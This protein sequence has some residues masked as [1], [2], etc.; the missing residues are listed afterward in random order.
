MERRGRSSRRL[1]GDRV[2]DD[3]PSKMAKNEA[4][5]SERV[6]ELLNDA[7]MSLSDSDKIGKLRQVQELILNKEPALLDNFTDE[8]LAFQTDRSPEVR[9]VV[10]EFM[11]NACKK[12]NELLTKVVATLNLLLCD[13]NVN[14]IKKTIQSM[15]NLYRIVLHWLSGH[16]TVNDNQKACWKLV[17]GI[18]DHFSG[19][20]D[21]ENDGVRTQTVKFMEKI[22]ITL[23]A[24]QRGS[25]IPKKQ[26]PFSS[27]DQIPTNHSL[28][29]TA[30]LKDDGEAA[31]QRLLG[32]L[33]SPSISSVNL[34]AT[35]GT[36][37]TIA[38]Q[39]P[40]FMRKVVQAFE[41]LHANL[42]PTLAKTQVSSVR[43]HLKMQMMNMLR[44]Q[45]SYEFHPQ[46]TNLLYDLGTS[47]SEIAKNMPKLSPPSRKRSPEEEED[48]EEEKE[49]TKRCK[50][51]VPSTQEGTSNQ[52]ASVTSP[53]QANSAIDITANQLIPLLNPE[54]VAN[55]VLLSMVMLPDR[56]P[57][58]FQASYTPIES[59]GTEEQIE[60]LAR[61][62]SSQMTA[63][64]IGS[65]IQKAA[66][67][68]AVEDAKRQEQ[69]KIEVEKENQGSQK[70]QIQTLIG[71]TT[72]QAQ[73]ETANETEA[74]KNLEAMITSPTVV[75]I[76]G[77]QRRIQGFKIDAITVPLDLDTKDKIIKMSVLR[78]LKCESK[79]F[80]S[81][82]HS[83]WQKI[84][85]SLVSQFGGDLHSILAKYVLDDI[86]HRSS[87]AF[88]WLYEEFNIY[89][90]NKSNDHAAHENYDACLTGLLTG[91]REKLETKEELFS[92]LVLQAPLLTD[93]A[94]KQIKLYCED[95]KKTFSGVS[96]VS[97]L[98][99][100]RPVRKI[101]FLKILLD[102]CIH[103]N[104]SIRQ[105]AIENV[106]RIFDH[107]EL[108]SMIKVYALKH[109]QF[110]TIPT[111]PDAMTTSE[112]EK[113][114]LKWTE[115]LMKQCLSLFFALL[116]LDHDF[117]TA[118]ADVYVQTNADVKRVVLRMID[119][120]LCQMG[121]ESPQILHLVKSCPKGAETLVTRMLHILTD[122]ANPSA[123]LVECVRDLYVKRVP[124]VRFL[125]PVLNGLEKQEVLQAIPKLVRLNPPVVKGV[126]K[127]LLGVHKSGEFESTNSALT[128]VELLVALHNMDKNSV[129]VKCVIR[130][131]SF[132]FA[133]SVVYTSEVLV[134]VIN[135]L[136]EQTEIPTLLMRTVI[137]SLITYPRLSGFVMN[138]LQRLILKRVWEQK[139][140]WEGFIRCCQRLKPQ[141]FQVL[142]QLPA[143]QLV[144][145]FS[146][147]PEVRE[148]L[149]H[150]VDR[151][152]PQQ[153]VHI[154]KNVLALV[155]HNPA[156]PMQT[157]ITGDVVQ[158]ALCH[159]SQVNLPRLSFVHIY[160]QYYHSKGEWKIK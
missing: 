87:L 75:P 24:V 57:D 77:L 140:V 115:P 1:K 53:E 60:H 133:E 135:Q 84:L 70:L 146:S 114:N 85:S 4:T 9:K 19:L 48:D 30:E 32:F 59:A 157:H 37:T 100:C 14:V 122:K 111:P 79:A 88:A 156:L 46:I 101:Q 63:V 159:I 25:E 136:V 17:C 21:S 121:M 73:E 86:R 10:I 56:M 151:F 67:I 102:L 78:V 15:T 148:P 64:G 128:P 155:R 26:E 80:M 47:S 36:L 118:L 52:E 117:I 145:V 137:Q 104:E 11:E 126:F 152:T 127:R 34:M 149:Q 13:T 90:E 23:S 27:L 45:F 74:E 106:I 116:P 38:K 109:I 119:A 2:E 50:K 42:P 3:P 113:E 41:M 40:Q 81:G 138:V 44:H 160:T 18:K 97:N 49:D 108:Q 69:K 142:L 147:A 35:M 20:L 71:G 82:A 130:A 62:L 33:A 61:L 107:I 31:F 12:D 65:G 120:P 72:A 92:K 8:V 105:Q 99:F 153:L 28:L 76:K 58:A 43:K 132:C 110:L 83:Q 123:E 16:G 141:S 112:N 154:D 143:D 134:T 158:Y 7:S 91:I 6:I 96:L 125:I 66:E 98:I 22:V 144:S 131:T 94:V 29:K 68:A 93:G 103:R 51:D 150:Y 54:N 55:L 129:D 39:R 95:E 124:D 89:L 5:T 139:N